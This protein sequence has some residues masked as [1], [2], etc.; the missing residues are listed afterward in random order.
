MGSK[1]AANATVLEEGPGRESDPTP[2]HES[3]ANVPTAARRT[4]S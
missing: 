4:R 1:G 3:L 2:H